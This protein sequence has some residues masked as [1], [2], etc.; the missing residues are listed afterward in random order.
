[1]NKLLQVFLAIVSLSCHAMA[2][3]QTTFTYQGV[4]TDTGSLADGAYGMDFA[5]WDLNTGGTQMGSTNHLPD[6]PVTAGL[7]TVQL[8][9]GPVAFDGDQR[10]LEITLEG[11][12]LVP[13]QPITWTPYAIQTRGLFVDADHD[14]GIGTVNP[15]APLE[16]HNRNAGEIVRLESDR[17]YGYLRFRE[18]ADTR[19]LLGF[20][21]DGGMLVHALPDSFA[22]D[23]MSTALHFAV[24]SDAERGITIDANGNVGIGT[25][26]VHSE[27]TTLH[28]A[29]T[30]TDGTPTA[31]WA[32]AAHYGGFF[33]V[34]DDDGHAVYARTHG[35]EARSLSGFAHGDY[36]WGVEG[37]AWGSHGVGVNGY[38]DGGS[39]SIAVRGYGFNTWDFYAAG[40]GGHYGSASSRRWKSNIREIDHPLE[41]LDQL[42]GVYFDWREELGG[43]HDIGMIAEEV[44]AVVPELV[45]FEANGVDARGMDYGKLTSL[46]VE[47]LKALRAEKDRELESLRSE[48]NELRERVETLEAAV[49]AILNEGVR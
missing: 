16:I 11:T 24:D 4:L 26:Q 29:N 22:I 32:E 1:M 43:R 5:L 41:K 47:A 2:Q 14:V 10:W 28:V 12:V 40:P 18:G 34:T 13:R 48:N 31:I 44:G 3:T 17:T 9:F 8:D 23:G 33:V 6:V 37:S 35:E 21:D 27:H 38:A 20:G 49:N 30:K 36:G 25:T 46:L 19:A 45:S 15:A 42:R 7:F 39:E